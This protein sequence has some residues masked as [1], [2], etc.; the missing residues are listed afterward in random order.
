MN[1]FQVIIDWA[2]RDLRSTLL[3]IAAGI[4]IFFIGRWLAHRLTRYAFRSMQRAH[5]DPLVVRFLETLIFWGLMATV[6][7][8]AL[9]QAGV[10]ITSLTALLAAAGVGIGL[11]LKDSLSNVASGL[12]ILLNKPYAINNFVD[13]G[14]ATG[15][16][17]EVQIFNTVLR[18]SDN[19]RVIV[20][21]SSITSN[22]IKNY[23]AFE[24]RRIDLVVSIG[25]GDNIGLARDLLMDLM[26]S[27]PLVLSVPPPT[28]DV[29]DLAQSSVN[30]AAR[31]WVLTQDYGRVRSDLLEQLK[32]RLDESGFSLPYPQQVVHVQQPV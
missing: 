7:I 3:G 9:R 16:V 12:M 23:S 25:Y 10:Y 17:E 19:I 29:L 21:N 15:S 14:G 4:L 8:A 5:L 27:H 24:T 18:T 13:V 11:A 32:S 28:V 31:S 6:I 30:L 20:P 26:T 1:N 2:N 22:N